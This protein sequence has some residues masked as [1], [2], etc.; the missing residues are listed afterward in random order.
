MT[1]KLVRKEPLMFEGRLLAIAIHPSKAAPM[2]PRDGVAAVAGSGIVDDYYSFGKHG[3]G[4]AA[5][6]AKPGCHGNGLPDRYGKPGS[7]SCPL[8]QRV[9]GLP[10]DIVLS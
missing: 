3:S 10:G 5:P 8:Q 1:W 2:V 7:R 9:A 4:I 6:A